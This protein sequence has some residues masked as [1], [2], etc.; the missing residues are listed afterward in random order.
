MNAP[1][2]SPRAP[3]PRHPAV[4]AAT[5]RAAISHLP[6]GL[7]VIT[8]RGP[9]G[10]VGC[11][12]TAVLS[13]SL[14]PPSLLV[15]LGSRSRTLTAVLAAR[16]FAVN[17]LAWPDRALAHQFATAP[18]DARF[19]G[20]D[21]RQING[22]PVLDRCTAGVVCEV[23]ESVE[24]FDHTVLVGVATWTRTGTS[25]P[26][27]LYRRAHH[28]LLIP[29]VHGPAGGGARVSGPAVA[30]GPAAQG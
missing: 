9:D 29:P 6:T 16:C 27:V 10:P 4:S 11:T 1:V 8:A 24:L 17:V 30:E 3:R 23:R 5:Y 18:A 26:A 14:D 13:L 12:V 19:A 22:A 15:S 28:A 21:V 20:V 25:D 7:T 2:S